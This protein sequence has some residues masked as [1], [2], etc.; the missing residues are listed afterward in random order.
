MSNFPLNY[1]DDTTLPFV[2]DNL[3]DI[4][5]EAINATRDA[6]FNIET[7]IGLGASG[8]AGSIAQ[9][10]GVSLLPSGA[11]NPSALTSLGLVT[12]PIT[13]SQ[14]ED[15]ANIPESKLRL[16]YR[17]R[18]LFNYIRDN[19]TGINTALGWIS[20]S[21]I[22]LEPHISGAIYRH[23]LTHIDINSNSALYFRDRYGNFRTTTNSF[24]SLN[25]LND[26]LLAHQ[27]ADG[28]DVTSNT[29]TTNSGSTYSANYAH[30]AESIFINTNRFS[31]VPE[32][33]N[34]LQLFAQYVDESMLLYGSR[35][36]NLYSN[37]ISRISRSSKLGSQT[38]GPPIVPSTPI[39]TYL[40]GIYDP[41]T[42]LPS[43]NPIDNI[44]IGDDIIKFEPS[45]G[46]LSSFEFD[47]QFSL[48]KP[49]D[50]ISVSYAATNEHGAVEVPYIIKEKKFVSGIMPIY[51]VRIFG[52]NMFASTDGY[53]SAT[54]DKP[55]FNNNKYG[56]L[57]TAAANHSMETSKMPSLIIGSP[58]NAMALGLGFNPDLL[59]SSHYLLYLVL[60][61]T[62]FPQDGAIQLP[63]IDVTGNAGATPGSY[64][65]ESVIETINN[66]FRQPGYNYRF[67]AFSYLGELGIMMSDCYNNAAFSILNGIVVAGSYDQIATEAAYPNNVVGLFSTA[68][69]VAP[70]PLGF[71]GAGA[72]IASPPY[73]TTYD[74]T[75]S[76]Q[77]PTKIFVPV[78]RSNYYV[79]GFEKDKLTLE[80]GQFLDEYGDGY[81]LASIE[82]VTPQAGRVA[83]K[84]HISDVD[85]SFTKLKVG[86]TLV[87]QYY[88]DG[89]IVD[90][91]RFTIEFIVFGCGT[92]NGTDITV[93]DGV[94]AYG[95]S[96][97][98]TTSSGLVK[99]YFNSDSVSFNS[100]TATDVSTISQF[101]RHFE[102]FVDENANTFTHERGRMPISSGITV[103]GVP[104]YFNTDLA[105]L[106]IVRI[107]PK[108]RGYQFGAT[109][110]VT[111]I[112]L[113]ILSFEETGNFSGYLV[114]YDGVDYTKYG[115]TVSG[116]IGEVTRFYDDTNID[117]IDILFDINV[118]ISLPITDELIDFQLFPSLA[119]DDE[120]MMIATCQHNT[121]L[122]TITQL[123]DERQFG[124][125]SEKDLTTSALSYIS[126]PDKMLHQ[127]GVL[128]GFDLQTV[129]PN[130][131]P[132]DNQI[133]LRG[134]SALVSGKI[135]YKNSEAAAI[136]KIQEYFN[137]GTVGINWALCINDKGE[138]QPIPL[139]DYDATNGT[140]NEDRIFEA[141]NPVTLG[142]YNLDAAYFS[143]IVNNRK[144]LT[145]LYIVYS[146]VTV[147]GGV[148][149]SVLTIHDVRKYV[150]DVD[151]NLPMKYNAGEGQSNFKNIS[152]VFNWLNYNNSFNGDV[153]I[154]G[155]FVTLDEPHG[156]IVS[157]DLKIGSNNRGMIVIDGKSDASLEFSGAIT[158]GS[159]VIFKDIN[160]YF[161]NSLT[162][163]IGSHDIT[164]ENC[165]IT[166][167]T[168]ISPLD[169]VALSM[170]NSSSIL[171]KDC[172]IDIVYPTQTNSGGAVI[173]FTNC[174]DFNFIDSS[175]TATYA[176]S[177]GVYYPGDIFYFINS[178]DNTIQNS[179]FSGTF[180]RFIRLSNASDNLVVDN[181]SI[182][183]EYNP[184]S[185]T[186]IYS[187]TNFVNSNYGGYIQS[188][189]S[190]SLR[191]IEIK[192]TSF[193]YSPSVASTDRFSFVNFEL[194]TYNAV[195][196]NVKI[197]RCKFNNLNVP[198]A[199]EDN[200]CAISIINTVTSGADS[201]PQPIASNILI[202]NN[203]CNRSQSIVIT[204]KTLADKM[205]YPGL[206]AINCLIENN[207]C[208][209]IGYWI[210]SGSKFANTPP[211][212]NTN[213]Y[214]SKP[215][216]LTISNNTCYYIATQDHLGKYFVTSKRVAAVSTKMCEYP[217]GFV[218]IKDNKT[219]WIHV[220]IAYEDN[221]K[222][223]IIDNHLNA[224]YYS[225]L[226][227]YGE[228]DAG[229]TDGEAYGSNFAIFVN[230][231]TYIATT[232]G[233]PL[234]GNSSN[235]IISGNIIGAGYWYIPTLTVYKY[236]RGGIFCKSSST[237]VNN[238]IK[239]VSTHSTA[240]LIAYSGM[241]MIITHNKLYRETS[242]IFYYIGF[243]CYESSAWNGSNS[244]GIITENYLDF[245]HCGP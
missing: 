118:P 30:P 188:S 166:I 230:A 51:I 223:S 156:T 116:R 153:V 186:S 69:Y 158:I 215:T 15:H 89:T 12:L 224:Y 209:T 232:A 81:W 145:L 22:K 63:V 187:S 17:T 8:T 245:Y 171:F 91:G 9:R 127:N 191:N 137:R 184:V 33:K 218:T 240:Q 160:L 157:K 92:D 234:N 110:I 122:N 142:T 38:Q 204:S 87:V 3:N 214:N 94:H 181:C 213:N 55:L 235:C 134:G 165:N 57:A 74:S 197:S 211:S 198:L 112:S 120:M 143:D 108:L 95:S 239:G 75:E 6:V 241:H 175:I 150:T 4:G 217:S 56:V 26:E 144:D 85:L 167:D 174:S 13:N 93:Y 111:K 228:I 244:I 193:N 126:L 36:Q 172:A 170:Y 115:P 20:V 206:M 176:A 2:N 152:A 107:S 147:A 226:T 46:A 135:I 84:Y 163:E 7:E 61:P 202:Q 243:V 124:D 177:P 179:W 117:Y 237:I 39:R 72:A 183:S 210:G 53:A 10:L 222:L 162:F 29:I 132:N 82:E 65:L 103:N 131:N 24:T 70:D 154:K 23:D 227:P 109:T 96:P 25:N 185:D 205:V 21:G 16:D 149:T 180:N 88:T 37:G 140:P 80:T 201:D 151:A 98:T 161:S 242:N 1:D 60:Y 73:M 114:S 221:S 83:V 32:T 49:G 121:T 48:V 50:I 173:K 229:T 106:D 148:A 59:D 45:A 192:N 200:K 101:K 5:G 102:V 99:I 130:T 168:N 189:I 43:N 146:E 178:S 62:G 207:I 90:F 238:I 28:T 86:K 141:Y 64:T 54:I 169:N 113:R 136:P 34:D 208:G 76:A 159:N 11:I 236:G 212:Y 220:G 14:I 105:M 203:T 233:D 66:K 41:D 129:V 19:V 44:D 35:F 71:G 139:L 195:L 40:F 119:L 128:K 194:T 47:T 78:T 225:Y 77:I 104:L 27:F 100:E 18:D 123:R 79:N 216:N 67:M 58:R 133:Y 68:P 52:K 164:F 231:N 155:A 138:Y 196:D 125:T 190:T 219:S 182:T 42:E 31:V 199:T 97:V